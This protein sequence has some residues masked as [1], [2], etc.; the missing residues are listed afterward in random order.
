[1]TCL[2][3]PLWT[4][5]PPP[6]PANSQ[7]AVSSFRL[8]DLT[9]P[10]HRRLIALCLVDPFQ[11]MA[12]VP[13]QQSDRWDGSRARAG[14]QTGAVRLTTEELPNITG[15]HLSVGVMEVGGGARREQVASC[16]LLAVVEAREHRLALVAERGASVRMSEREW[17]SS[18]GRCDH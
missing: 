18:H 8:Q 4:S 17:Q 2:R 11:R 15:T 6:S 13:P 3:V 14:A 5:T 12:N 1:M 16:G 7:H 9:K 10:G